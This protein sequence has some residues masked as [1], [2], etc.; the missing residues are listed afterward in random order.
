MQTESDSLKSISL[1]ILFTAKTF[2]ELSHVISEFH[3]FLSNNGFTVNQNFYQQKPA[4]INLLPQYASEIKEISSSQQI[5][6]LSSLATSFPFSYQNITDPK[7]FLLGVIDKNNG[8]CTFDINLRTSERTNSNM[9]II[10]TSGSGKSFTT[11]KMIAQLLLKKQ[12]IIIFDPEREYQTLT[13]KFRGSWIDT[14]NASSGTINPFQ[15]FAS[16][17]ENNTNIAQHYHFLEEFFKLTTP[18]L[19]GKQLSIL[20]NLVKKTYL[21]KKI[22]SFDKTLKPSQYPT[23]SSLITLINKERGLS[24]NS[25]LISLDL[26][27]LSLLFNR[28]AKNNEDSFL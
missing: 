24:S 25:P 26:E 17:D 10:G 14:G 22:V 23:F 6:P 7:G 12:K 28:F 15:I 13:Q 18:D 1:N 8:F 19:T 20:M 4:F 3:A 11:K 16:I 2:Q 21:D 9:F 27:T 5:I